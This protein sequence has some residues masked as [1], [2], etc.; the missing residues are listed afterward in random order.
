MNDQHEIDDLTSRARKGVLWLAS[1]TAIWQALSW[2]FTI[3][4]ARILLPSDYGL[5]ALLNAITPYFIL[6][7]TFRL[8]TWIV[9]EERFGQEEQQ[10][11]LTLLLLLA[12]IAGCVLFLLAPHLANFFEQEEL[13]LLYRIFAF[14][15]FFRAVRTLAEAM[16]R[17]ELLFKPIAVMNM[18]VG[19]TR[20]VLQLVLALSGFGYWALVAGLIFAELVECFWLFRLAKPSLRLRWDTQLVVKGLR[21]GMYAAGGS[22]LWTLGFTIDD[23]AIGKFLGEEI[24]GYYS[25]AFMLSELPLSKFNAVVGPV[26]LSYYSRL[27]SERDELFRIYLRVIQGIGMVLGPVLLGMAIVAPE[28]FL[29]ILGSKWEPAI[30]MFQ[31]LC[32]IWLLKAFCGNTSPMFFALGMPEKIFNFNLLNC[33]LLTPAFLFFTWRLGMPGVYLTWIALFPI[34]VLYL[35]YEVIRSSTISVDRYIQNLVPPVVSTLAMSMCAILFR[36]VVGDSLHQVALLLGTML[37][38]AIAYAA[39]VW[40]CFSAEATGFYR[41]L[42]G[43]TASGGEEQQ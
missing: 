28:V 2:V 37:T 20:N 33:L 25:M 19:I 1:S 35:V 17:R 12:G 4:I 24:L 36:W 5:V 21:F 38:G 3:I 15:F 9:Q 30:P 14:T 42:R 22:I 18:T 13:L 16:L 23:I 43:T 32:T 6:F 29:I 27:K 8:E 10:V 41:V 34:S 31:V 39:V 7:V 11:L 40:L 26:L